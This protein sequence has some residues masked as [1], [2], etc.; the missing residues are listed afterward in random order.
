MWVTS[1]NRCFRERSSQGNIWKE[2]NLFGEYLSG[3]WDIV[4]DRCSSTGTKTGGD[5]HRREG[6]EYDDCVV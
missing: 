2:W 4:L 3:P 6:W 1:R 5:Q